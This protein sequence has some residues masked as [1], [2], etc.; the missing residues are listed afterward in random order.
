[1]AGEWAARTRRKLGGEHIAAL[2]GL[3]ECKLALGHHE[4]AAIELETAAEQHPLAENLIAPLLVALYRSG[5]ASDSLRW[6]AGTRDRLREELGTDPSARLRDLHQRILRQDPGLTTENVIVEDHESRLPAVGGPA[7]HT[8]D[9]IIQIALRGRRL[10]LAVASMTRE[11]AVRLELSAV[12]QQCAYLLQ[13]YGPMPASELAGLVGL[14][15][16]SVGG[17]LARLQQAGVARCQR[18]TGDR[19]EVVIAPLPSADLIA[20]YGP[21][22]QR[23]TM[24]VRRYS[25]ADLALITD[26]L[27]RSAALLNDYTRTLRQRSMQD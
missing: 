13:Q 4:E 23:L 8:D 24:L 11:A 9:V 22:K 10:S 6:Y 16:G 21:L 2:A 5:R 18:V 1:V 17:I 27:S 7:S 12:E 25:E 19:D 3:G 14:S 20:I 15:S 26:Y